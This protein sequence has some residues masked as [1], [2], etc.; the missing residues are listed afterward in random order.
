MFTLNFLVFTD[1]IFA[2]GIR[3]SPSNQQKRNNYEKDIN[4]STRNFSCCT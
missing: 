1:K 4:F 2:A 3:D